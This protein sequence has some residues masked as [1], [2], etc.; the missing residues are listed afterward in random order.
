MAAGSEIDGV[1][2]GNGGPEEGGSPDGGTSDGGTP[3]GGTPQPELGICCSGGGIRS[4]AFNLGALQAL[5]EQGLLRSADYLS[6]VSGGSYIASAWTIAARHSDPE[7]VRDQPVFA[8]G[9]PEESWVRNHSS[10][11][12]DGVVDTLR[13]VGVALVGFVANVALFTV[14]L[15]T[16]ARPAGWAYAAWQPGLR[17]PEA[18]TPSQTAAESAAAGCFEG[19]TLT[20]LGVPA[21]VAAGLAGAA[22][23]LGLLVRMFMPVWGQRLRLYRVAVLLV[24][25][26]AVVAVIGLAVPAGIVAV[27]DLLGGEPAALP[28]AGTTEP[29]SAQDKSASNL[30]F[31]AALGAATTLLALVTQVRRALGQP[32]VARTSAWV[33]R[34]S[35]GIRRLLNTVLGSLIAPL[36]LAAAALLIVDGGATA[37]RPD[38]GE[39]A[40]WGGAAALTL[41]ML[42]LG[43][44]TG[45]SLHPFYKRRLCRTFAVKRERDREN[46]PTATE[47]P[48]TD[49]LRL[50]DFT[51]AAIEAS[52]NGRFPELLVCAAVNVSDRGA[53]PPGRNGVSFVFAPS[54]V[55][56]PGK[57]RVPRR[58]TPWQQ[59]SEPTR[60][61]EADLLPSLA[62][63]TTQYEAYLGDRRQRDATLPAAVAI[64][65]AAVAP[66]MG[67]MT[68]PSLRFLLALTNVR[69]GVWLPNPGM[70][71]PE[72]EGIAKPPVAAAPGESEDRPRRLARWLMVRPRQWHLLFEVLGRHRAR[73][74]FLYV[75]DGGHVE[76]LG[77][78]ELLRRECRVIVCLDAAGG[79]P[80]TFATLGEALA[81][82]RADLSAE[83]EIDPTA[84][85]PPKP[86]KDDDGGDSHDR[87][88]GG[89]RGGPPRTRLNAA[90]HV[91]GTIRYKS[92]R[93]GTLVYGKAAVTAQ[94]PWAVRAYGEKDERFPAHPTSDQAYGGEMFEAYQALGRHVGGGCGRDATAAL[95]PGAGTGTGPRTEPTGPDAGPGPTPDPDP[96][97][98][99][100]AASGPLEHHEPVGG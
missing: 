86:G 28:V 10:Y 69:L 11:L 21:L 16:V 40:L 64:S 34:Q 97:P 81:I 87:G 65:G 37:S 56:C 96:G 67:K 23:V 15:W 41:A 20:G 18:C 63:P 19:A 54:K 8:P 12:T 75:T 58:A 83:I 70:L 92:G 91:T 30:G 94:A 95:R 43:D 42:V 53:M 55:G 77:L 51:P 78:V 25:L 3:D 50:S 66:A 24:A 2:S 82:A 47:V 60:N 85:R 35:Q 26:A 7:L 44:V 29:A 45:W 32:V 57:L 89:D 46:G 13:L 48:F 5:D 90:D 62:V 74:R 31:I 71:L 38:G 61:E 33:R 4:A 76:N 27:R 88:T 39:L 52:G 79:S 14:L 59:L 1:T 72:S 49:V 84:L 73:S 93:T 80:S 99:P 100:P 36:A 6:A 17:V 22:L 98:T 9:S 68:R